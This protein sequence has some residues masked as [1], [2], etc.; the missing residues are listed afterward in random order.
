MLHGGREKTHMRRRQAF[1]LVEL[2]VVLAII[3]ILI[4]LLLPAVQRVRAAANRIRCANNLHQIGLAMHMYHDTLGTLPRSRMCPR[5]WLNGTDPDC[6]QLPYPTYYTGPN[7]TWWAPYD[8]RPG[9]TIA[10]ALPDY[11][12]S[13]LLLPFVEGNAKVF[14]CP[15]GFDFTPG[16][17]TFG[18]EVQ[19]S[20]A[21]NG[22]AGGPAGQTLVVITNGSGTSNVLLVWEHNN[23]PSCGYSLPGQPTIP[24][25]FN[26]PAAVRHYPPRH[27]GSFNVLY[28]DGHVTA[29]QRSDLALPLFYAQ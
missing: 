21:M 14:K 23:I 22:V 27:I 5:P 19:V 10:Q 1:T 11:V 4:A 24:W 6:Q 17:P 26:D 20:Y 12:P 29:M 3:G 7:E 9:T 15:D 18:K 13:G 28:C 25:P 2:L 16:S 8:N